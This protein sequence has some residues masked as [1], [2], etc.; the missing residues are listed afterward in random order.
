MNWL[1]CD[2][3][4]KLPDGLL[5]LG[6]MCVVRVTGVKCLLLKRSKEARWEP[7]PS[8]RELGNRGWQSWQYRFYGVKA[9]YKLL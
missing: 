9:Y 6:D 8:N 4:G 7:S 3:G 5:Q 1:T 2:N